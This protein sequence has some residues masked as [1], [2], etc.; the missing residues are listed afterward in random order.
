MP[1]FR[2]ATRHSDC[3][4]YGS[5]MNTSDMAERLQVIEA[6]LH[7]RRF[8]FALTLATKLE[9]RIITLAADTSSFALVPTTIRQRARALRWAAEV[10]NQR[11]YRARRG[12]RRRAYLAKTGS[13]RKH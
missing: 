5:R 1:K 11:T 6:L 10:G 13:L 4:A 2:G 12:T 9:E 7:Q 3:Y 8:D